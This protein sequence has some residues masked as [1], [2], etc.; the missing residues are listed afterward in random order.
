M[1]LLMPALALAG[2]FYFGKRF[3]G[4]FL[5]A[6][7][8]WGLLGLLLVHLVYGGLRPVVFHNLILPAKISVMGARQSWLQA[9]RMLYEEIRVLLLLGGAALILLWPWKPLTR[10]DWQAWE[11]GRPALF[12]M[13]AVLLIPTSLAGKV[14]P[15]GAANAL[16]PVVYFLL[17]GILVFLREHWPEAAGTTAPESRIPPLAM[18]FA[19]LLLL[20]LA[21][22][23]AAPFSVRQLF[24][25]DS[26]QL[27]YD[28]CRRRPGEIYFP[29][30]AVSQFLAEGR[31]YHSDWGVAH[32]VTAGFPPKRE[33]I[34][35]F[36]PPS[37][38]YVAYPPDAWGANW[39][40]PYLA[41]GRQKVTVE[42]L[43]G[44]DVYRVEK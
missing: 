4:S 1:V 5:L 42:D 43:P 16:A 25:Q 29:F 14:Y 19:V 24:R 40:L 26:S 36:A 44:F 32:L 12:L 6:L 31:M 20:S 37:A 38:S 9:V 11:G 35:R 34:L 22:R 7:A 21:P 41:P 13:A 18:L 30:N 17:L 33:E 27:A 2:W 3:L 23:I 28:Y 39:L 15:G 10:Q 8:G